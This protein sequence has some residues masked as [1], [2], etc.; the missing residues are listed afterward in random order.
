[1]HT[2]PHTPPRIEADGHTLYAIAERGYNHT[3]RSPD[4]LPPHTVFIDGW[5]DDNGEPKMVCISAYLGTP[6]DCD[7]RT[8]RLHL[9]ADELLAAVQAAIAACNADHLIVLAA[10]AR[11]CTGAN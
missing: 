11:T 9:R 8:I 4:P 6:E 3:V 10:Q 1:M 2:G 5:A 7:P